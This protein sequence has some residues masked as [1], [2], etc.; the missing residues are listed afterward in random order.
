MLEQ[1]QAWLVHG[2]RELYR[3]IT[4]AE[5]WPG[6]LLKPESN[7]FPLTHDLLTRLGALDHSM[8]DRFV[9]QPN[10][11]SFQ[12]S[13]NKRFETFASDSFFQH[14][15]PPTPPTCHTSPSTPTTEPESQDLQHELTPPYCFSSLAYQDRQQWPINGISLF[16]DMDMMAITDYTNLF[17]DGQVPSENFNLF[18]QPNRMETTSI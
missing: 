5:A 1:Q 9:E 16:D 8:G 7:G 4:T 17:L 2:L 3:R 10:Y 12:E 14:S 11:L 15:M 18:F 6:D 13:S